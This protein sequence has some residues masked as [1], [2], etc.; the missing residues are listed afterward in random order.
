MHSADGRGFSLIELTIVCAI[1]GVLAAIAYTAY[2]AYVAQVRTN[3][4]AA[5]P[6]DCPRPAQA[7]PDT[8]AATIAPTPPAPLAKSADPRCD[9]ATRRIQDGFVPVDIEIPATGG[10]AASLRDPRPLRPG[11]EA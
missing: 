1:V 8:A 9:S 3:E 5:A 2:D 10:T 6:A 7:A 11:R 4:S